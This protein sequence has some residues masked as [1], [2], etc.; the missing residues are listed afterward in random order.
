MHPKLIKVILIWNTTWRYPDLYNRWES[1]TWLKKNEY[2][3]IFMHLMI[4]N[5][6]CTQ[7]LLVFLMALTLKVFKLL[8][9]TK[10]LKYYMISKTVAMQIEQPFFDQYCYPF[11]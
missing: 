4:R 6:Y 1:Y 2:F 3:D 9:N 10:V 7:N 11:F 5:H 8:S